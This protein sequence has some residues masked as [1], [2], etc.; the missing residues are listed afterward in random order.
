MHGNA[1]PLKQT[2]RLVAHGADVLQDELQRP[3]V[4]FACGT[5]LGQIRTGLLLAELIH[6]QKGGVGFAGVD[7]ISTDLG[8]TLGIM[9]STLFT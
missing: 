3:T 2:S 1:C 8:C 6:R 5:C 7:E 9:Q 4:F